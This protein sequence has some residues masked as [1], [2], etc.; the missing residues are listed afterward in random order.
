MTTIADPQHVN[1]IRLDGKRALI[2]GATKG[3]GAEIARAFAAT[4]AALVLSGRDQAALTAAGSTLADEF[5]VEIETAAVDLASPDGPA[6]L[7]ELATGAFDGLDILVNNNA[8]ISHPS[9]VSDL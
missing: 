1:T 4:G 7:A 2:T 5:G 6:E 8:G 9:R 3:I